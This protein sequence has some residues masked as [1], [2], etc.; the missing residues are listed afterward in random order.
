MILFYHAEN[1]N[2]IDIL[3]YKRITIYEGN[4]FPFLKCD[5]FKMEK[6]SRATT[7][8]TNIATGISLYQ[9]EDSFNTLAFILLLKEIVIFGPISNLLRLISKNWTIST[10]DSNEVCLMF[11]L[12]SYTLKVVEKM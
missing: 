6:Q 3:L 4:K 7:P 8:L 11:Y 12:H 2:E 5:Q 10:S 1:E 9:K